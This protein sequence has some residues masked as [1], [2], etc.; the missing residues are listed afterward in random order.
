MGDA[1]GADRFELY[2]TLLNTFETRLTLTARYVND[3]NP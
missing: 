2:F 3:K 1:A